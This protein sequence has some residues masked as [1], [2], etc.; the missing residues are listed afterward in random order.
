MGS[1][2]GKHSS[3]SYPLAMYFLWEG[4][5]E[6]YLFS[7]KGYPSLFRAPC[8]GQGTKGPPAKPGGPFLSPFGKS[9]VS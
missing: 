3:S 4:E 2:I 8:T 1:A 5:R 9:G 6:G 7:K